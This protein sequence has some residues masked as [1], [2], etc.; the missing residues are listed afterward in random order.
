MS[1]VI[2]GC[3]LGTGNSCVAVIEAGKPIVVA[4]AE[5]SRTTPSVVSLKDGERKVG[6]TANRQRIVHPKET[7]Y[8]VKRFMGCKYDDCSEIINKVTYDVKNVNGLPRITVD[9]REYSPEEISSYIVQKMKKTAEDYLGQTVTDMVITCPAWFDNAAREAT[10]LA[11]EMCGVNVLR[12]INEPTSA[13][14]ASNLAKS[15]KG[16]KVMVADIGQG[17]GQ[18]AVFIKSVGRCPSSG[19]RCCR[20]GS[21]DRRNCQVILMR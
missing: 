12:V 21:L 20:D 3:D 11:G 16:I 4:N 7:I 6:T 1:K 15:E 8:N 18:C 9:G 5:G 14:L 17:I 19:L 10:K 2:A 13:I